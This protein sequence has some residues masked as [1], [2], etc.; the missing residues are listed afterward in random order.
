MYI[1]AN[2]R[3]Q[4]KWPFVNIRR[5]FELALAVLGKEE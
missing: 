5:I 4:Q 3:A 1:T 2:F